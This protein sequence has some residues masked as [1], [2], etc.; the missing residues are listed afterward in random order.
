M[1]RAWI[2][3]AGFG[4]LSALSYLS[5]AVWTMPA[6][7]AGAGNAPMFDLRDEGYNYDTA[8]A[9]LADLSEPARRLYLGPQRILDTLFP[10]GLAGALALTIYLCLRRNFGRWALL[11]AL[12][13]AA[14]FYVDMLENAAVASLMRAPVLLPD[15]VDAAST[16]TVLKYQLAY[17]SVLLCLLCIIGQVVRWSLQRF[18]NTQ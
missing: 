5:M 14:Y 17:A 1:R 2:A 9:Y 16:Y 7:D 8:R 3:V 11:G 15:D 4:G 18:R 13:P 6:I 10:F 12:V